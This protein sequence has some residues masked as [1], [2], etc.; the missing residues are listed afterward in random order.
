MP[1]PN[2]FQPAEHFQDVVRRV[3]NPE[4]RDFF[5]DIEDDELDISTPR[6]SLRTACTHQDNDSLIQTVGRMLLFQFAVKQI[7]ENESQSGSG[8]HYSVILEGHPKV[9][10]IFREDRTDVE[11]GYSA[12]EGMI[13][14]RIMDET[15]Q[16]MTEGKMMSLAQRI[17]TEFTRGNGY[18]WRKGR[19]L[20]T[21]TDKIN[22]QAHSIA[23]RDQAEGMRLLDSVL[24]VAQ[25]PKN[26]ALA[27]FRENLSP[28]TAYPSVPP[29]KNVLGKSRRMPRRMPVADV[30][31][32]WAYIMVPG[33]NHKIYLVDDTGLKPKA[34]LKAW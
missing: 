12:V 34:L 16:S 7:E 17:K 15:G 27:N 10:L 23:C 33:L 11:P 2:N 31:F 29:T 26:L 14:F 8:A 5:R 25:I 6:N 9:V 1:L 21:Y 19:F 24:D 20:L 22:G 28:G 32:Q 30:R 4:I 3:Q 13:S 18:V